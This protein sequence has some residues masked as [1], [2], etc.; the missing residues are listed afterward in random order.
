[1]KKGKKTGREVKI[2]QMGK[3]KEVERKRRKGR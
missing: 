3:V 1:M 2:K